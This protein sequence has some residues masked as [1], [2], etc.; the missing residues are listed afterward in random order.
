M[1]RTPAAV[2]RAAAT[3]AGLL[4]FVFAVDVALT[5]ARPSE[6]APTVGRTI[7]LFMALGALPAAGL[8]TYMAGAGEYRVAAWSA[9]IAGSL[10]LAVG[11]GNVISA[12]S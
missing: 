12:G 2:R 9:L 4:L 11:I 10:L 6:D 1:H 3:L 8:A 5:F 7:G